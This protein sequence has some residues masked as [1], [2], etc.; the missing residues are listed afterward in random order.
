[1]DEQPRALDVREEVVAEP[2]AV[3]R[4]LDQARDVGDDELALLVLQ[5]AEDRLE[6]RERVVGDLRR[7]ARQPRQQRG[8]AGVRQPDEA[9][10]GEQL[11]A[12]VD[13]ALD[14]RPARARRTAAPGASTT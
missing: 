9:D 14:P 1:M 12:Q 4:A 2:G 11:E 6:R 8:L 7:G 3:R 5:R 13:P 10:V